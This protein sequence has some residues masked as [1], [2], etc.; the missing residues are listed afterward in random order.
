MIVCWLQ[1]A[2][3]IW[4]AKNIGNRTCDLVTDIF[5]I[6]VILKL[7]NRLDISLLVPFFLSQDLTSVKV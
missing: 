6:F 3:G 7:F 4:L 1:W 2:F 5:K